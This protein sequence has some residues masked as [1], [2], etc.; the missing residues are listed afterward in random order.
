MTFSRS[1]KGQV[2]IV[3]QF[4]CTK[5]I[6]LE[7]ALITHGKWEQLDPASFLLSIGNA[8]L[9][10]TVTV[11]GGFNLKT[12]TIQELGAEP[13][14]RLGLSLNAPSEETEVHIVFTPQ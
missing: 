8:H 1:G 9:K 6:P 10:V 7:E 12:E 3:D 2:E 11:P 5:V 4:K 14:T 13:F